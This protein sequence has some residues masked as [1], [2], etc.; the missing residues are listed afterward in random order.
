MKNVLCS[1]IGRINIVKMS[2]PLKVIYRFYA[3]PLK[4]L[5]AFIIDIQSIIL[6]YNLKYVYCLLSIYS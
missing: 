2:I 4:N 3:I 6:K 1:W 5:M